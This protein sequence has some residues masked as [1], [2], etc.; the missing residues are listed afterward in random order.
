MFL[1]IHQVEVEFGLCGNLCGYSVSKG[2]GSEC[3]M[4]LLSLKSLKRH[5]HI[6]TKKYLQWKEVNL[7][8]KVYV[9]I[10][11]LIL[12]QSACQN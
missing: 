3:Y 1:N 12:V 4:I 5:Y 6:T 9:T 8:K 10:Q 11:Q 7:E 2:N